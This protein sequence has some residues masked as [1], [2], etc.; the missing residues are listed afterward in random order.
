MLWPPEELPR[1]G[2]PCKQLTNSEPAGL[3][4][5]WKLQREIW[6]NR[7]CACIGP[8]PVLPPWMSR[9]SQRIRSP[10]S[11]STNTCQKIP[12]FHSIITASPDK[13][14]LQ[15]VQ[16]WYLSL[17]GWIRHHRS[18]GEMFSLDRAKISSLSQMRMVFPWSDE[19]ICLV[20]ILDF[21]K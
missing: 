17:L 16:Y 7:R 4:R 10:G 13:E 6:I 19:T 21:S 20:Q 14:R 5:R 9:E 8:R 12:L 3:P 1:S 15:V 2:A 11:A 18:F